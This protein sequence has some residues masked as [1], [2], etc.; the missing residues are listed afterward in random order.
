MWYNDRPGI[1]EGL[2]MGSTTNQMKD[3]EEN[4]NRKKKMLG[5]GDERKKKMGGRSGWAWRGN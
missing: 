1:F 4:Q 5:L 3:I 2:L